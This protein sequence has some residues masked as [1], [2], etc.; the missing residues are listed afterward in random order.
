M[1]RTAEA[2]RRVAPEWP[3]GLAD[4]VAGDAQV[5]RVPDGATIFSPGDSAERFVVVLS[6]AVRVEQFGEGGRSIVL[7]RVAP[8]DSCVMTTCCLLSGSPVG[9]YGTAE[10]DVEVL[11]LPA[12]AFRRLIDTDPGFRTLALSVFTERVRELTEVIEDLLVRR[13]DLR[14]AAW[15]AERAASGARIAMTHQGIANELGSAREVVS[16]ILKD[17]E[18]RG[19]IALS[20]GALTV[21][22]AAALARLAAGGAL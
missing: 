12:A 22:D 16:R 1:S 6:G 9:A 21:T 11:A 19:W 4:T 5:M 17:F 3:E 10:G 20:R 14:L 15:L 2:L 13:V 8:G 7:Y 18:R